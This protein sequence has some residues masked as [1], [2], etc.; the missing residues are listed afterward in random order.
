LINLKRK[1]ERKGAPPGAL[2]RRKTDLIALREFRL[3]NGEVIDGAPFQGFICVAADILVHWQHFRRRRDGSRYLSDPGRPLER[4]VYTFEAWFWSDDHDLIAM[5]LR[6]RERAGQ[7]YT[8]AE[9]GQLVSLQPLEAD[10]LGIGSMYP[11]G[12]TTEER[13]QRRRERKRAI[14]RERSKQRRRA[15]GAR[16][17]TDSLSAT[18]PWKAMGISRRT[19]YRRRGTNEL[20]T[21]LVEYGSNASVPSTLSASSLAKVP[22]PDQKNQADV[23]HSARQGAKQSAATAQAGPK[24]NLADHPRKSAKGGCH[25]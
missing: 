5:W 10:E 22:L 18:Q 14:E 23:T 17:R 6:E 11:V 2:Y 20:A 1:E 7:S 19:W 16:P 15:M 25:G 9:V 13:E 12:E 8:H 3:R 4:T 21:V 24:A